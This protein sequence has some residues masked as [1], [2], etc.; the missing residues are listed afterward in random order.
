LR[1][2]LHNHGGIPGKSASGRGSQRATKRGAVHA[3]LLHPLGIT[4]A[5]ISLALALLVQYL[6]VFT[7][8]SNR[9]WWILVWGI[10]VYA[11]TVEVLIR[12]RPQEQLAPE[13]AKLR[14]IRSAIEIRLRERQAIEGGDRPSELTRILSEAIDQ[15][16]RQVEPALRQLLE[17]QRVLFNYLSVIEKGELPIPSPDVLGRLQ[18]IYARQQAA[19]KECVQQAADAAGTLVALLQEGDDARVAAQ[20]RT[21]A[22]DLLTL[23]DAIAEVLR[24]GQADEELRSLGL[25]LGGLHERDNGASLE[26]FPRLVQE[27]LR[28]FN[29]L[30]ALSRC[31]L[32]DRLNCTLAAARANAGNGHETESTPLNQAQVLREILSDA[33]ERLKP[34]GRTVRPGSPEALQYDILFEGYVREVSTTSIMVR[35]SISES[36]FHRNRREAIAAVAQE[37]QRKEELLLRELQHS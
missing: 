9:A 5:L 19:T 10:L 32:I 26:S 36:T 12:Y 11:V 25:P 37:L 3:A 8:W 31:E 34:V 13:I 20:A 7:T 23:Y 33:I 22:R 6:P 21:W 16:D 29:D 4:M 14:A 2:F 30:A 27:A 24:G 35:H 15:L 17:R 28:R 1:N 18:A